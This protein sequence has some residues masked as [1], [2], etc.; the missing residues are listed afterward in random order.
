MRP[1][2]FL[3][4]CAFL[5]SGSAQA[6]QSGRDYRAVVQ[7][8][9]QN[10]CYGDDDVFTVSLDLRIEV[11]NSARTTLFFA[12]DMVPYTGRVAG[13]AD[14]VRAGQY[15]QEWTPSQ[16]LTG[17]SNKPGTIQVKPGHSFVLRVKYGVPGRYRATPSFAGTL[18]AGTYALQL[19][20]RPETPSRSSRSSSGPRG[21]ELDSLTTDPVLFEIPQ[22]VTAAACH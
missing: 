22:R 3:A 11:V 2:T 14:A 15:V 4:I 16:Y 17:P 21:V 12:S 13:N 5:L 19:V 6:G 20:L 8:V 18:T 9:S 7:V 10:Y 1:L